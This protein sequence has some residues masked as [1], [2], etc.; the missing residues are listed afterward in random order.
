MEIEGLDE[1]IVEFC[2]KIFKFFL[3]LKKTKKYGKN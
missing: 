3:K 2:I 1:K